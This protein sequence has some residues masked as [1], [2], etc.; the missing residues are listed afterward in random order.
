MVEIQGIERATRLHNQ[1][2]V[3]DGC[4][5]GM[6]FFKEPDVELRAITEGGVAGAN[7]TVAQQNHDFRRA[8][9]SMIQLEKVQE[10]FSNKMRICR[11][12]AELKAAREEERLGVVFHFQDAKPMEDK[13]DNVET[14]YRLGLR[15]LQLTYNT[16]GWL[17]TGC[18]ERH[19]A[20]LSTL[21]LQVIEECNRLGILVD[22]S[23]CGWTSAWDAIRHSKQ[24]VSITHTGAY[25]LCQATGRNK[26]D[27]M[28]KAV[29]DTGGVVGA[30][31]FSALLRR[32]AGS[33]RVAPTSIRDV[34]GHLQHMVDVVGPDHVAIGSDLS[35]YHARTLE[36]PAD[37]SLKWYRPLRPDVFGDGPTDRYDPFPD[38]L[39]SHSK[40]RN[41]TAG[42]VDL[43][44]SDEDITKILGG[45]WLRLFES[46][47]RV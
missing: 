11:S 6:G 44:Y 46:V 43:G 22:V 25:A 16:Q 28:L 37:S 34:L 14:F 12:V 47:W 1:A 30:I 7:V 33:H 26:P 29:A 24:P 4:I 40:M 17:G 15:V 38:G 35:N 2:Y 20:G 41:L 9:D 31:W 45:N 36:M 39:D 42:L 21:G 23:H 27:D 13:L 5:P 8:L 10:R 19:D 18:A 32:E 3:F